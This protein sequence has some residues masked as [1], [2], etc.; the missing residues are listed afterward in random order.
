MTYIWDIRSL[1]LSKFFVVAQEEDGVFQGQ[2]VVKITLGL[3]LCC[4]LHLQTEKPGNK[5][6]SS[7][8]IMNTSSYRLFSTSI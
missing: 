7:V 8:V 4:A 6:K 5:L 3:P 1:V 2:S